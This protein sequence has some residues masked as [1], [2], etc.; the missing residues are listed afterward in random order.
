[1]L[2]RFQDLSSKWVPQMM[3]RA[4]LLKQK[5]K[6]LKRFISIAI[7]LL[8]LNN[9]HDAMSIYQ[10]IKMEYEIRYPRIWQDLPNKF[11]KDYQHLEALM[12]YED[13]Y[14]ALLP[15][16]H[17]CIPYLDYHLKKLVAVEALVPSTIGHMVNFIKCRYVYKIISE[18]IRFQQTPY[19]LQPVTQ[20]ADLLTN[21][22]M[23]LDETQANPETL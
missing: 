20:I 7:E 11:K 16:R 9:F 5:V 2:A 17:P 12:I 14:K 3:E 21:F 8:K 10:G 1:M 4:P 18:L 6:V 23:E 19:N 22:D 15:N 13:Q